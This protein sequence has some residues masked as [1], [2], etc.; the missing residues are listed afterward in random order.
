MSFIRLFRGPSGRPPRSW[1]HVPA[2]ARRVLSSFVLYPH[3]R[4]PFAPF[5]WFSTNVGGFRSSSYNALSGLTDRDGGWSWSCC[6]IGDCL[7]RLLLLCWTEISVCSCSVDCSQRDGGLGLHWETLQVNL[8]VNL[9]SSLCAVSVFPWAER[10]GFAFVNVACLNF[11]YW[12]N[13]TVFAV[14]WSDGHAAVYQDCAT[15]SL[16]V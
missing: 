9:S 11:A 8:L 13:W 7:S 4:R 10:V 3:G 14:D 1:F 5:V 15:F 16:C 2:F 12:W 6:R